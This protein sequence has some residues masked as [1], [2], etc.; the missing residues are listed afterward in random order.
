[1]VDMSRMLVSAVVQDDIDAILQ[2]AE[3][4]GL[5]NWTAEDYSLEI[6][7]TGS[8]FLK[9]VNTSC[10]GF[11]IGRIVPGEDGRRSEAEIYNI[12]I[13]P[14]FQHSGFG[15]SL[16]EAFLDRC[17]SR[18]VGSVFLEVRA[19]NVNAHS[20]YEKHQFV[21]TAIRS[22]FYG[23]PTEDAIVMRLEVVRHATNGQLDT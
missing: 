18:N 2:I 21:E 8:V 22:C 6:G 14:E 11:I 23:D 13:T 17:S 5:S 7:R 4:C 1:M 12:G 19:S 9:V 15:S 3:E 10:I 16:I 20:F